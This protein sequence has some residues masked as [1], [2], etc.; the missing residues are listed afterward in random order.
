M[1]LRRRVLSKPVVESG[2]GSY[3]EPE[4]DFINT[5]YINNGVIK[6]TQGYWSLNDDTERGKL[7]DYYT[8]ANDLDKYAFML[9]IEYE[10]INDKPVYGGHPY[11]GY[12][13]NGGGKIVSTSYTNNDN[14]YFDAVWFEEYKDGFRLDYTTFRDE[15]FANIMYM[16]EKLIKFS[17]NTDVIKDNVINLPHAHG[18]IRNLD[19][20]VNRLRSYTDLGI[21]ANIQY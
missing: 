3:V 4:G 21:V 18:V 8:N 17:L 12:T 15:S 6:Q 9:L 5:R 13:D 10:G 7:Y 2:G 11:Y 20:V 1:Y 19:F 16:N 14:I